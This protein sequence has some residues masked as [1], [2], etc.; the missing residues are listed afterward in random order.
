MKKIY[1]TWDEHNNEYWQSAICESVEEC[2][3]EARECDVVGDTIFIGEI[4]PYEIHVD[5]DA[6]LE[7]IEEEACNECGESAWDWIPSRDISQDDINMFSFKLTN[8]VKSW[9]KEH[10]VYPTF[11]N[12]INIR[13]VNINHDHCETN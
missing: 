3:K 7:H 12:I 1:Y 9:L 6:L 4:E 10:N 11:Y 8:I 2:I 5:A 13:E